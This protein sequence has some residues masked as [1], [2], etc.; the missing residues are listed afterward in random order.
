MNTLTLRDWPALRQWIQVVA[1]AI[2]AALVS[3]N[4]LGDSQ[5]EQILIFITAVMPPTL[6]IFNSASGIRTFLYTTIAAG[7]ALII[8]L[9]VFTAVQVAPVAN[10]LLAAIGTGIAVTHTPTPAGEQRPPLPAAS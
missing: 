9:D 8:G 1:T 2:L 7:Q 6:S 4:W 10:I 5:A 3:Y